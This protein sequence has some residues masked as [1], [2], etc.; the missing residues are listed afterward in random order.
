MSEFQPRR[1]VIDS[2]MLKSEAF[3]RRIEV[4][5]RVKFKDYLSSLF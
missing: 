2:A 3:R 5:F 4:V 1:M